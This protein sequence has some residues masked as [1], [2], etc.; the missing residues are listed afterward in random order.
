MGHLLTV[1]ATKKIL[2]QDGFN[3]ANS[4]TTMG[5]ADTGQT[6]TPFSGTWGISGN[7]AYLA[8][9]TTQA[10]N[11]VDRGIAN[12]RIK[13]DISLSPTANRADTGLMIRGID[14]NNYLLVALQKTA[15][16][17]WITL[18]KRDVSAF[19][20]LSQITTAGLV[21]GAT[22]TVFIQAVGSDI[23]VYV[24]GVLKITYSLIGADA[25]KFGT[26]TKCGL[27]MASAASSDDGNSRFDDFIMEAV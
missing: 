26:P 11:T 20:T 4:A 25:T 12:I 22:Y 18:Y 7:K 17:D 23:M 9:A 10:V 13:C 14:D 5:I 15:T 21:N 24:N 3:R 16:A 1:L 27:R 8:S 6:W 19:T 2:V